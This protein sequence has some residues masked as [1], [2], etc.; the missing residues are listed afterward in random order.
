MLT[1]AQVE[2]L[3]NTPLGSAPNRIAVAMDLADVTQLELQAGTGIPQTQ[4]S[5]IKR[6][7]Y[8]RRGLPG[9]RMR[10]LAQ[11]FGVHMEDLF[12]ARSEQATS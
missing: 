10:T 6:G 3:R 7:R 2:Q 4:I 5:R 9:E 8:S 12:P 11:F 1:S